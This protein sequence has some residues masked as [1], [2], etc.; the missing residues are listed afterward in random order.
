MTAIIQDTPRIRRFAGYAAL[1]LMVAIA[2]LSLLPSADL[3]SVETSDK[4]KHFIAYAALAVPMAI[5][6]G[7]GRA[8]RALVLT[9]AFGALME[10]GQLLAPT[11]R[12]FSVFD[13]L[14]N[15]LGATLGTGIALALRRR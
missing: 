4:T 8:L 12:D 10:V 7:P 1:L 9:A 6:L 14:A 15:V 11:G 3:P 5:R 13:E 2:I